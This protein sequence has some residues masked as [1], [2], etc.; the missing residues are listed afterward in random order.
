MAFIQT[1]GRDLVIARR[2]RFS[3]KR[4]VRRDRV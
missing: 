1:P 2:E 3:V 4:N